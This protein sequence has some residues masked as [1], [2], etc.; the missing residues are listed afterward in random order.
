M[1][2]DAVTLTIDMRFDPGKAGQAIELLTFGSG[3]I[4]AKT[5]C[6][7]C[8]VTRDAAEGNR[9]R[10]SESWASES[11]FQRH[12]Q[13][14]EFRLV[15]VAMELCREEPE[16]VVGNFSGHVGLVYL[17]QLCARQGAGE[18]KP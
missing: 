15:L 18:T 6:R 11:A 4:E 2:T 13:S 10:Y 8:L 5:G 7:E 3:R 12:L 17:Q 9:V 16:V 1:K 14:E